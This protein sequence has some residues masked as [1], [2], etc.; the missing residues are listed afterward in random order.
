MPFAELI[1]QLGGPCVVRVH[2]DAG[3]RRTTRL[4]SGSLHGNEPSGARAL[5]ALLQRLQGG[6]AEDGLPADL[7]LVFGALDAAL[8]EPRFSTRMRPG[9]RDLN[10]CFRGPFDDDNGRVA[11]AVLEA[12]VG[13]DLE[14]V[15]DVHNTS[16]TNPDFVIVSVDDDVHHQLAASFSSR[17]LAWRLQLGTLAEV[18][19]GRCP[20]LTLEAG[21]AHS[22][23]ADAIAVDAVW[24]FATMS[25]SAPPSSSS[26][27]SSPSL[28]ASSSVYRDPMRVRLREGVHVAFADADTPPADDLEVRCEPSVDRLNFSVVAAGTR[29]ARVHPAFVGMPFVVDGGDLRSGPDLADAVFLRRGDDIVT[30]VTLVPM[31]MT[32]SPDVARSDC[33][34]YCTRA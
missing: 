14:A 10:R 29:V 13:V 1:E 8:I 15:L 23:A 6:L 9:Q 4:I 25:F 26:S 5:H 3:E 31:M 21:T 28:K 17:I 27:S 32:T 24:R 7:L 20:A 16:G 34:M 11:R 2:R 18:F 19:E 30:R 22:A 12:A 33:L